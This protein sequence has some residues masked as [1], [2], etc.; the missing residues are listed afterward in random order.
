[1]STPRESQYHLP[2]LHTF[3]H[4]MMTITGPTSRTS[5]FSRPRP[6]SW[7]KS[8]PVRLQAAQKMRLRDDLME[9]CGIQRLCSAWRADETR[10]GG[11]NFCQLGS[12]VPGFYENLRWSG[13]CT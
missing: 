7:P 3:L 10:F 11:F 12:R 8:L 2:A 1:M 9:L 6:S 5:P 13:S 4:C